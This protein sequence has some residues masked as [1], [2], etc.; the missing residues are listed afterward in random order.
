MHQVGISNYFMRKMHGQTTLKFPIHFSSVLQCVSYIPLTTSYVFCISS[1][2]FAVKYKLR[3]PCHSICSNS[4]LLPFIYNLRVV[5]STKCSV[6]GVALYQNFYVLVFSSRQF[7]FH[8]KLKGTGKITLAYL[9]IYACRKE[10]I[11][12]IRLMRQKFRVD[13]MN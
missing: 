7:A 1:L 8:K 4:F 5:C 2:I 11:F 10:Q 9:N 3:S 6:L 12:K 13:Q